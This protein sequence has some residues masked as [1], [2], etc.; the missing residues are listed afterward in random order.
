MQWSKKLLFY[1]SELQVRQIYRICSYLQLRILNGSDYKLLLKA[2][3][4]F[5]ILSI[6]HSIFTQN[7][8]LG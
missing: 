4:Y 3:Q 8:G 6:D 5:Q 1:S 7:L 2:I